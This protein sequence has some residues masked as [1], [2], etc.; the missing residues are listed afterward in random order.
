VLQ[1][2]DRTEQLAQLPNWLYLTGSV[3]ALQKVWDTFG[4]E[5]SV[6]GA[7]AMVAHTETTFVIDPHGVVRWIINSD[8]GPATSVTQGSFASLLAGK[9]RQVLG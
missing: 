9:A 8:P 3:A 6:E 7:G 1:A 2:F 4:I 5:V